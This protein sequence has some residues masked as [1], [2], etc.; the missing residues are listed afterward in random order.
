MLFMHCVC[1]QL[2][3]AVCLCSRTLMRH[4]CACSTNTHHVHA[5]HLRIACVLP[6]LFVRI[7][8]SCAMRVRPPQIRTMF[9]H[10]IYAL[11]VYYHFFLYASCVH[12]PCM[13]VLHKYAPCS[14]IASTHCVC[15][16]VLFVRIVCL[17]AMRVRPP[18][19]RTMFM[20]CIYA[21][22]VYY[23]FFLYASCVHA[24]CMCVLHKYAPC[25]CI[26]STHRV[27]CA[28]RVRP[29]QIRTMFMHC[30]YAL[31]VYYRFFLYASC[32]H[33]P[34]MCVLHKCAP[35]S[36]IASTHCVCIAVSFCTHRVFMRHA[37]ACSTNAHQV[38]CIAS[39]H[40]VYAPF[41][42]YALY[43]HPLFVESRCMP[44]LNLT[45]NGKAFLTACCVLASATAMA[46]VT[47]L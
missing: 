32:V 7:M 19:I 12:A 43:D 23:R 6:F 16:T 47:Q 41:V 18:Q 42:F 33:T 20:H 4:A 5:L 14:C 17:C 36:C 30:I 34:C 21:L 11:R 46:V 10:C 35:C 29:P 24:P 27:L 2:L 25:S 38:S 31:R 40:C 44:N 22:R 8:C 45:Y 13:C 1:T 28:M 3:C 9:M 15:I 37:C 26:A 39:S